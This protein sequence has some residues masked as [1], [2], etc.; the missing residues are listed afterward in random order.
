MAK[1]ITEIKTVKQIES[2]MK[3]KPM[4]Q[5]KFENE[6]MAYFKEEWWW[7]NILQQNNNCVLAEWKPDDAKFYVRESKN[8][9]TNYLDRFLQFGIDLN[10]FE[11]IFVKVE[12]KFEFPQLGSGRAESG[13]AFEL[14]DIFLIHMINYFAA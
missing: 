9:L 2:K 1:R 14:A 12:L 7:W 10:V 4:T 5:M 8:N 3:S 6:R 11:T 13:I